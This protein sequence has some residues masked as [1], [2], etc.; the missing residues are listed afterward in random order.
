MMGV[1]WGIPTSRVPVVH[2]VSGLVFDRGFTWPKAMTRTFPF[3]F[4][5]DSAHANSGHVEVEV[6]RQH[7]WAGSPVWKRGSFVTASGVR[8]FGAPRPSNDLCNSY[9]TDGQYVISFDTIDEHGFRTPPTS[10]ICDAV[11]RLVDHLD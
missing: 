5:F 7:L 4:E 2:N 11:A 10:P 3:F 8:W 9:V 6:T 1:D